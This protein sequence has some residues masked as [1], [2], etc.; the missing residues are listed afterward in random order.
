VKRSQWFAAAALAAAGGV[1]WGLCFGRDP[2]EVVSWVALVPLCLILR[3]EGWRRRAALGWIFGVALW[4]VSIPWLLYTLRTF[5]H[6]P[7][8]VSILLLG[9]LNGYLAVYTALFTALGGAFQRRGPGWA[10]V[11]VPALWVVL[12]HVRSVLFGG[13]P[14][15]MAAYAWV[16]VPGVLPLASWIG[17]FGVGALV[18]LVNLALAQGL[19]AVYR[20]RPASWWHR[21]AA[22]FLA[23]LTL[24]AVAGRWAVPPPSAA[25]SGGAGEPVRILQPNIGVSEDFDWAQV[26]ANSQKVFAMSEAACTERALLVWPES[27]NWPFAYTGSSPQDENF[28]RAVQRLA[29]SGCPVLLNSAHETGRVLNGIPEVYNSAFLV[30]RDGSSTRYDK[31]KLVPW[32]EEVLLEEIFPFIGKLAREAGHFRAGEAAG[33]LPWGQEKLG[34]AICYEAIFPASVAASVAAGATVLVT[35]S[36]DAWYGDSVAL[37]QHFRAARFRAAENRRPMI[38]AAITG[39]SGMIG[40]DGTVLARLGPGEEGVLAVRVAG[41]TDRSPYSR[42]PGLVPLVCWLVTGIA[43]ILRRKKT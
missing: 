29:A 39:I 20:E 10:L 42:W 27:A 15:N 41:R 33:L 6:L 17:A 12:E 23:V 16:D 14:W 32:G 8:G 1:L 36:N 22:V 38:R 25:P 3:V 5:G 43:L 7:L 21:P 11:A 26:F 34:M 9:L 19:V 28:R 40:P 13:F 24:L 35:V 4:W 18:V 37:W 30:A 2:F 31:R